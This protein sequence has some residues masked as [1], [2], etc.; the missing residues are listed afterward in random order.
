[1]R[2]SDAGAS[3]ELDPGICATHLK[4]WTVVQMLRTDLLQRGVPWIRL[5]AERRRVPSSLNLG[6]RERLSVLASGAAVAALVLRRPQRAAVAT[7]L[8]VALNLPLYRVL[9]R[10]LGPR[11]AIAC[12]PLHAGHHLAAGLAV[13]L[14]LVRHVC[15]RSR[16][17]GCKG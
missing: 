15:D 1:M 2:L 11:R 8:L 16:T 4:D 6:M 13:P 3:I 5:L 7:A 12:V 17:S 9:L 10:A 14:G